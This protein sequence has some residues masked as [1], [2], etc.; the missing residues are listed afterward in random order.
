M[1]KFELNY[2]H[3]RDYSEKIEISIALNVRPSKEDYEDMLTAIATIDKMKKYIK[4][5]ETT[6]ET[7]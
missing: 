2:K 5:D 4:L 1:A 3:S 6:K 7:K